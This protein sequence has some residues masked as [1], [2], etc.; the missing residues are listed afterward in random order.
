MKL[1]QK[2]GLYKAVLLAMTT[3]MLVACGSD[4]DDEGAGVSGPQGASGI[5]GDD[6]LNGTDGISGADG[7]NGNDGK[8]GAPSNVGLTRLAQAPI[9]AEFT[10]MYLNE[11]GTFFINVQHPSTDNMTVD[12]KGHTFDKGTVGVVIGADFN[13][14]GKVAA[15]DLAITDADKEVV[16]TAVGNYQV[17]LQ[18]NDDMDDGFTA[19]DIVKKDGT[20]LVKNSNDPDFNGVVPDGNGGYY[21][22]TNW[23]DRTGGMSRIQISGL[24]PDGY[25]L[26]KKEGMLDFSS[27]DGTWVNCFG[28]VTPWGTPISAEELYYDNTA[29]WFDPTYKYFGNA[30]AVAQYMGYPEDQ[31][32]NWGNPYNYGYNVEVGTDGTVAEANVA[33]VK[34]EKRFALGRFS[35]EN[36]IVMPDRRTV[37]QSDDG[38]NTVFFKFVADIESDL[39]AGTLYAAKATQASDTSTTTEAAFGIEW[40]ML[41]SGSD[42]QIETWVDF[43]DGTFAEAKYITDQQINDWAEAKLDQDLDGV[44][45]VAVSPFE[46]DRPAFLETRKAAKALGATAEFNKME[47]V[48]INY[49]LAETWW[50]GGDADGVQ[51]YSY[52]AMSTIGGGMTDDEGAIQIDTDHGSCGAVYRM[53]L[54]KNAAGLVDVKTMIPVIVGGPYFGDRAVNECDVTNISNPDNLVILND[55]RVLIG[56]DSGNHENNMVWLFDDPAI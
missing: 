15:L 18:Q 41:G 13:S 56:E 45:G 9:G 14:L 19:G 39:S 3:S 22:Y 44:N 10:G 42:A 28:T 34:I 32:G 35:H 54:I 43:Y 2:N 7:V 1:L 40:V 16:S 55:G 4:S 53:K 12:S 5:G 27:V 38:S 36:A 23:E 8:D 50:D 26:V 25:S 51:A 37:F 21:V 20:T 17:L 46:D 6:G 49:D 31:S 52:M 24:G 29:D 48:N 30:V 47:G 33:D 11:D